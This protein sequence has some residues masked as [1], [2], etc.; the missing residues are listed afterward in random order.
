MAIVAASIESNGW[1]L[2]IDVTGVLGNFA[3]YTLDPDGSRRVQLTSSHPGFVKSGGT[4]IAGTLA[5]ALIATKPL[6]LPVNPASPTVAVIDETDLGGGVIRVRLAL[7]EHIYATDTGLSLAVLAGWRTGEGAASGIAV[8]NNSTIVAPIPIMRWALVPYDPVTGSFRL[9]LIV[10][11]HHPVGFEPVAG[12]KFTATD[13]TNTKTV[14]AMSLSTDNSYGDNLR[15]YSVI[16]DPATGTALTAGLLRGDAEVY[17]WLGVMRSTDPF[18]SR[19]MASLRTDSLSVNAASPFVVPYDPA[20]TRYGQMW[21]YVDAVNGTNV[22]S[23]AMVAT[24]LAGAKAVA[25]ASRPRDITT[26]IQAGYLANRTLPAA[27][28]LAAQ[29]RSIDGMNIVVAP[30]TFTLGATAITSGLAT[31]EVPVRIIGD[32]D[33]ANPRANCVYNLTVASANIRATRIKI[34]NLTMGLGTN[35]IASS[36]TQLFILDRVTG[37]ARTGLEANA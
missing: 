14:W 35:Q 28:G 34:D 9:S 24:T 7:N 15:C 2:R 16:I 13:G 23:A 5:R 1:V 36:S 31:A 3:N 12:V 22:A 18:G 26:A 29:T 8:T 32:P 4:A 27:N 33:D 25:A 6:R 11:S 17:P 10:A 20:G 21:T 30:G 37:Q 19:A